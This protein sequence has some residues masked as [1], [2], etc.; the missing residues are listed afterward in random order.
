M[1]DL[2]SS[3]TPYNRQPASSR[4]VVAM[5]QCQSR[6]FGTRPLL[7]IGTRAWRHDE[8]AQAAARHATLLQAAGIGHGHR[9][10]LMTA[11]RIEF[12]EAFLGAAWL[13]AVS[14]PVGAD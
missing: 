2:N 6:E 1:T 12:L 9:V 11:N 5:L 4:T 13:G 3:V 14:V 7:Q 10:A 8:A